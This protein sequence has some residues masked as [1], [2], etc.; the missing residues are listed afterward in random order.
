MDYHLDRSIR[1]AREEEY[2]SLY[3]WSLQEFTAEGQ[4]AGEKQIP[5]MWTLSFAASEM[6]LAHRFEA[7]VDLSGK[8][9]EQTSSETIQ[10]TLTPDGR[11]NDYATT[12]FSMFG[13]NRDIKSFSLTEVLA[14]LR[15]PTGLTG[16]RASGRG[17]WQMHG[18]V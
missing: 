16:T 14:K 15:W 1:F 4:A 12:R 7:T 17:V 9:R 10:L 6:R 8:P 11:H 3:Q 13:T 18:R 5:W 2:K